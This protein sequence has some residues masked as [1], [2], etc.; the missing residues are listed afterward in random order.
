MQVVSII[1]AVLA[2]MICQALRFG[3]DCF[4]RHRTFGQG[5]T[6]TDPH[7]ALCWGNNRQ[8][9]VHCNRGFQILYAPV[10]FSML[11]RPLDQ[12]VVAPTVVLWTLDGVSETGMG[13]KASR[14]LRYGLVTVPKGT[15]LIPKD[16]NFNKV[17]ARLA[18]HKGGKRKAKIGDCR[19]P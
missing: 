2:G 15:T 6:H 9:Q 7:Q 8:S 16:C 10:L 5:L 11:W 13:K 18:C 4:S 3:H 1:F 17:R 19:C 14:W 12:L